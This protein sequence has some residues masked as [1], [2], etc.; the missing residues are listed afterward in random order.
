MNPVVHFEM[1]AEDMERMKKFYETAF[2]WETKDMGK[3]MGGYVVVTTSESEE[4]DM[5]RLPKKPG[6]INGGF[7]KKTEDVATHYPSVVIAVEDIKEASKKVK[8]AGGQVIGGQYK[9]GEPDDIP[10]VGLFSS[11]IDTEGNR[12][13]I[14]QP[15]GM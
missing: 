2:G 4:S 10:G 14:L 11:I 12:V 3:E 7:Y 13:A 6:M 9:A 8:E 15:K 1:P 5:A